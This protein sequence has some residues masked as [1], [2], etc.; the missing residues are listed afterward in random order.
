M[1]SLLLKQSE[2][3]VVDQPI[4]S[5]TF[6]NQII[7]RG[8]RGDITEG[9]DDITPVHMAFVIDAEKEL[10]TSPSFIMDIRDSERC[11]DR[12]LMFCAWAA[13][14]RLVMENMERFGMHDCAQFSIQE[15]FDSNEPS[16]ALIQVMA[17]VKLNLSKE[18]FV[19][20]LELSIWMFLSKCAHPRKV[21]RLTARANEADRNGGL[22]SDDPSSRINAMVAEAGARSR[23]S[24]ASL[25]KKIAEFVKPTN[26]SSWL[27]RNDTKFLELDNMTPDRLKQLLIME[28]LPEYSELDLCTLFEL[29]FNFKVAV[30]IRS[31][32]HIPED[33]KD[34]N[35][36]VAMYRQD[37][38][39]RLCF[40]QDELVRTF[41]DWRALGPKT[42][43]YSLFLNQVQRLHRVFNMGS[44]SLST[45]SYG[46][47]ICDDEDTLQKF[48]G[49]FSSALLSISHEMFELFDRGKRSRAGARE[50]SESRYSR[51]D[52]EL[53]RRSRG[54]SELR[55]AGS[56]RAG[57]GPNVPAAIWSEQVRELSVMRDGPN[58]SEVAASGSKRSS[59]VMSSGSS[60][61]LEDAPRE[62]GEYEEKLL[63]GIERVDLATRNVSFHEKKEQVVAECSRRQFALRNE[64]MDLSLFNAQQV[65]QCVRFFQTTYY[66]FMKTH[67]VAAG[68]VVFSLLQAA[69]NY[70]EKQNS[71][72]DAAEIQ[73]AE[74]AEAT[75]ASKRASLEEAYENTS[76]QLARELEVSEHIMNEK[77][78]AYIN[79]CMSGI[80][81]FLG[82][83]A[84]TAR[85]APPDKAIISHFKE[86]MSS[87]N[88]VQLLG[89]LAN[90]SG[91]ELTAM[92]AHDSQ[93]F[94]LVSALGSF[95]SALAAIY[96]RVLDN[97]HDPSLLIVGGLL[98][99]TTYNFKHLSSGILIVGS[100][101]AGKSRVAQEMMKQ[102]PVGCAHE[103]N[104]RS[105]RVD[106]MDSDDLSGIQVNQ[107][108]LLASQKVGADFAQH[109]QNALDKSRLTESAI[110][111]DTAMLSEDPNDRYASKRKVLK[112][113]LFK[114]Y[115]DIRC[116]NLIPSDFDD[117]LRKRFLEFVVMFQAD[118]TDRVV[119]VLNHTKTADPYAK[120]R[121][122][123]TLHALI[124]MLQTCNMSWTPNELVAEVL[125]RKVIYTTSYKIGIQLD[126]RE[127]KYC[128]QLASQVCMFRV[129]QEQQY[130]GG[131][132]SGLH[133]DDLLV[134][135]SMLTN[136]LTISVEDVVAA[137]YLRRNSLMLSD[138][139]RMVCEVVASMIDDSF[140]EE[141]CFTRSHRYD[142]IVY[143]EE[144]PI[145]VDPATYRTRPFKSIAMTFDANTKYHIYYG[146]F[147]EFV[148]HIIRS[149]Q[150][151]PYSKKTDHS[152]IASIISWIMAKVVI[153]DDGSPVSVIRIVHSNEVFPDKP[154]KQQFVGVHSSIMRLLK[155][156]RCIIDGIV[157]FVST[158]NC[159]PRAISTCHFVKKGTPGTVATFTPRYLQIKRVPGKSVTIRVDAQSPDDSVSKFLEEYMQPPQRIS[160]Y[161]LSK[162]EIRITCDLDEFSADMA[163]RQMGIP[164]ELRERL[165]VILNRN[166]VNLPLEYPNVMS[167][168]DAHELFA[169]GIITEDPDNSQHITKV[170]CTNP[171]L[172]GICYNDAIYRYWACGQVEPD[173]LVY[174][175]MPQ[176]EIVKAYW[177]DHYG[178]DPARTS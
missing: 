142:G 130:P 125:L 70:I 174:L 94:N 162:G 100:Q 175:R 28:S 102:L 23:H 49:V 55:G 17:C 170:M 117:A 35:A 15:I 112:S 73:D 46:P 118:G 44:E 178:F 160:G 96:N 77:Y 8:F 126:D 68:P 107:D 50:R 20:L 120:V 171:C 114:H 80:K 42:A 38:G 158:S 87:P 137:V 154:S 99:G 106:T 2:S 53:S 1:R 164:Y 43:L 101:A 40:P 19:R 18:D 83:F 74:L 93:N 139:H 45:A 177:R 88:S 24:S 57:R 81:N 62:H 115:G 90:V 85:L 86:F 59:S 26:T 143:P 16:P 7:P 65:E 173:A 148:Q 119:Q 108:A 103:S 140:L 34:E 5:L 111:V 159:I 150:Q 134:A 27:M 89:P 36:Y 133:G 149:V 146:S 12:R 155:L 95:F 176:S 51:D 105:A 157:A 91:S 79:L 10:N 129:I 78:D 136:F 110:H 6:G 30:E 14:M 163:A 144:V 32:P 75:R 132:L 37:D 39:H 92:T 104:A 109:Q 22:A 64:A 60:N 13:I 56:Q 128:A 124:N 66:E 152:T 84:P 166:A 156:E 47:L 71:I 25:T 69:H 54:H 141:L 145:G 9:R 151:A 172:T 82:L 122:L 165:T 3:T 41:P 147:N 135:F 48:S 76:N 21:P 138:N 116:T 113:T 29:V 167:T 131:V 67:Y 153:G 98:S 121:Q 61:T 4:T 58:D 168:S 72:D 169:A 33:F 123:W 63:E 31:N 127:I 11:R 161:E 97:Y 52:S